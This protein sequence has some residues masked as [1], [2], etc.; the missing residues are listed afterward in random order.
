MTTSLITQDEAIRLQ[1]EGTNRFYDNSQLNDWRECERKGYFRHVRNWRREGVSTALAFGLAWHDAMDIVWSLAKTKQPQ[2]ILDAAELAFI[3]RWIEEGMPD[4]RTG[5]LDQT[6]LDD[7][8][9]RTPG[10]A[11][12]MLLY[13]MSKY[14]AYIRDEYEII[15]IEQPFIVPMSE[16]E[17]GLFYIG[18]MDKIFRSKIDGQ[19]RVCT[20]D[21]KTTKSEG[22]YWRSGFF[23]SSQFEG[24]SFA[25]KSTYGEEF[26][27]NIIDGALVQKGTPKSQKEQSDPTFPMGI[28]F[29]RFPI[30][31]IDSELAQWHWDVLYM[32]KSVIEYNAVL[33]LDCSPKDDCMRAY[34]RRTTSCNNYGGCTYKDIC[35]V[36]SN[37]MRQLEPPPG[38][39]E[40]KWQP[41]DILDVAKGT[42]E[43]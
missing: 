9:P 34:P 14:L 37:P 39:I 42:K 32:V 21:H 26:W 13:Y 40:E 11:K 20:L 3:E 36:Y 18:R 31:H 29:P 25:A 19:K 38:F 23:P 12:E 27:G 5:A 33:L 43:E 7:L 8:Y 28:S 4:P 1:E 41:F 35:P 10:R 6:Q 22:S 2:E 16:D 30:Q 15:G 17:P 24:Y